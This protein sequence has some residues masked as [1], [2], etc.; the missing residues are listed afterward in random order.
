MPAAA[1]PARQ[2]AAQS[3]GAYKFDFFTPEEAVEVEAIAARIIPTDDTPGAREAGVIYFI[4]RSLV[5]FASGDQQKY[6]SQRRQQWQSHSGA[7]GSTGENWSGWDRS[8]RHD[9]ASATSSGTWTRGSGSWT[10]AN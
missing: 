10:R 1:N 2:A 5:T 4:D 8:H 9:G 6:W 3:T 7:T